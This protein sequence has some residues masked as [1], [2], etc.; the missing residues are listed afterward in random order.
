MGSILQDRSE[1]MHNY[2]HVADTIILHDQNPR[3][4]NNTPVKPDALPV[5]I[6]EPQPNDKCRKLNSFNKQIEENLQ[7]FS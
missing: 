1:T 7:H 5:P 6:Y 2:Q 3:C 4:T